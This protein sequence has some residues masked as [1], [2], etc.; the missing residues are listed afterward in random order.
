MKETQREPFEGV[1]KPAPLKHS[2]A[3][4]SSRR[5][6]EEPRMVYKSRMKLCLLLNLGTTT[7]L[8]QTAPAAAPWRRSPYGVDVPCL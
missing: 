1:G 3:G 6:N 7:D 4:Y 5:I 2:L 8:T